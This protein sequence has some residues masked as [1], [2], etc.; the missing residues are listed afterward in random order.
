MTSRTEKI[1]E[2]LSP[3]W[4]KSRAENRVEIGALNGKY[5]S[6]STTSAIFQEVITTI[7]DADS[8]VS[9]DLNRLRARARDNVRNVP[10]ATALIKRTCDHAIGANGLT[11]H[12][13]VDREV[14]GISEDQAVD[15]QDKTESEWKL[16]SES[17]ECDYYRTLTFPE[18]TYLTLQSELEGGDCFTVFTNVKRPGSDYNLKL[19]TIEAEY[20]SNPNYQTNTSNLIEGIEKRSGVPYKYYISQKHPGDRIGNLQNKWF[21]RLIY[22]PETGRRNVLHHF[23]KIRP[24]QTRGVPVLGPVTGKLLQIGRLSNAELLAA[25]INSFYTLVLQGPPADTKLSKSAP[26]ETNT[27]ATDEDKLTMGA[28]SIWRLKTGSS[29]EAF[30]PKRPNAQFEPFFQAMVSEIGAAV[31]VPRSLILMSFDKSYSASRGEVLLAW[32]YFLAK[33]THTAVSYCQPTYTAFLDEAVATGRIIAPGYFSDYRIKNAYC[34]SAYN[35]W[36]GP[37]RPAID[38]LKEANALEKLHSLGTQSLQEITAKTTGKQW[39]K[40]NEQIIRENKLRAVKGIEP[41]IE[42]EII[43]EDEE[44]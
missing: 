9:W 25:V 22:N 5:D 32:V 2:Y 43:E 37:T 16:Y 40:V 17:T 39:R 1:I 26:T 21:E 38:E 35:Q 31:G 14:L 20:I 15:W 33:R 34:G 30:D 13:Q 28:G 10:V 24:G 4:A 8:S 3:R 6:A 44:E 41:P 27:T 18:M 36:T 23:D 29:V 12:P 11:L 7:T 42:D 19:Q